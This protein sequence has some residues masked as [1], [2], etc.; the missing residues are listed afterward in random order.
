MTIKGWPDSRRPVEPIGGWGPGYPSVGNV[1]GLPNIARRLIQ[2]HPINAGLVGWWPIN[3]GQGTRIRDL[4]IY[5]NH[6][7]LTNAANPG[8]LASGWG[9]GVSQRELV[10]DASDDLISVPHSASLNFAAE[11]SV[12]CWVSIK[13]T[14]SYPT[15]LCKGNGGAGYPGP[16]QMLCESTGATWMFA[17]G[18][19][20]SAQNIGCFGPVVTLNRVYHLVGVHT[21]GAGPGSTDFL[22]QD[23]A[24]VKTAVTT[25]ALVNNGTALGIGGRTPGTLYGLNDRVSHVRLWNRALSATEVAQIYADK[26]YGSIGGIT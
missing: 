8:T 10:F 16:F 25:V 1:S 9:A 26:W 5:G 4:S 11:F 24:L 6:G 7:T 19:G 2:A 21:G 20:A 17:T 22:Y 12:S 14:A 23:G 13:S 3:E 18:N 15:L